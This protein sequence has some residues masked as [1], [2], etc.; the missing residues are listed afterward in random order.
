MRVLL[1]EDDLRLA[2]VLEEAFGEAGIDT[3]V[4]A[5]GRITLA[6]AGEDDRFDVLVL[7]WG[8][9]GLDGL[10]VCRRL[11][12]D[13]VA[14]PTLMLTARSLVPDRVAAL[15]GGADDHLAKPFHL[16]E[17]L[18]RVRALG[19]RGAGAGSAGREA[20]PLRLDLAGRRAW[21]DGHELALTARELDLLDLLVRRA[22]QVVG[23]ETILREVWGQDADPRSNTVDV[24]VAS[25]RGKL[26]RPFARPLLTT[27]RGHGYRLDVAP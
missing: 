26:D 5:D 18:A 4:V 7:D 24:H 19:R 21:R 17:L 9:P 25:L 15:D 22:G 12:A 27:V 6:A 2:A 13:G 3:E 10:S 14:T 8:L 16:E 23:R 1:A 20:G 11:R